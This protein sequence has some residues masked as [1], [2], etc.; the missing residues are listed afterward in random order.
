MEDILRTAWKTFFVSGYWIRVLVFFLASLCLM[1][2]HGRFWSGLL[3]RKDHP[4][5]FLC[6]G[7]VSILALEQLFCWPVVAFRLSADL[8]LWLTLA[9]LLLPSAAALF[10][11]GEGRERDPV[12]TALLLLTVLIVAAAAAGSVF[13]R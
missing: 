8:L 12:P 2:L 5:E 3:K 11:K 13:V 1:Y 7:L 4:L 10:L 6:M 9:V